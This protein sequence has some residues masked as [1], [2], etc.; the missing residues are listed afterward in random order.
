MVIQ[1]S[2]KSIIKKKENETEVIKTQTEY[3]KLTLFTNIKIVYI[4]N[5]G[6]FTEQKKFNKN[7]VGLMDKGSIYKN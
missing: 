2:A 6:D 3:K 1:I 4:G 5:L 7:S